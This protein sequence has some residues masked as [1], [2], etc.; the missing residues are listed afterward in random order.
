M[1]P[2]F[3]TAPGLVPLKD[4]TNFKLDGILSARLPDGSTCGPDTGFKTDLASI[5]SLGFLGGLLMLLAHYFLPVEF[6]WL[7]FFIC[8]MSIWLKA[9]GFYTYAAVWHDWAF[10]AVAFGFWKCNWLLLRLMIVSR[11]GGKWRRRLEWI[12]VGL[13]WFNVQFSGVG[14]LIYL[15]YKHRRRR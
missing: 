14:W 2:G 3:L 5:P 13:I 4:G 9:Y 7:G 6:L 12:P 15:R 8:G 11:S 1:K 10:Q